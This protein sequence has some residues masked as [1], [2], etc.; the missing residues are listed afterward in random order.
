VVRLALRLPGEIE[1]SFKRLRRTYP[2]LSRAAWDISTQDEFEFARQFDC[3]RFQGGFVTRRNDWHGRVLAPQVLAVAT[4]INE[5]RQGADMRELAKVL[6]QDIAM[7]YRLLRYVNT[8]ARGLNHQLS[9][10]E[11]ALLVLGQEQLDRWL[12]LLMLGGS[13]G[14]NT[15][16][17]ETALVRARFLEL[18]GEGRF[19]PGQC[20]RLFV[21]GLFSM[22]DIALRVPM[23]EALKPLHLPEA[24]TQALLKREGPFGPYLSLVEA[25]ERCDAERMLKHAVAIGLTTRK[26]WLG[27]AH[28]KPRPSPSR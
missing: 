24:A 21:L 7:S 27:S 13:L 14:G 26:P 11:Q 18:L 6:K 19:A 16:L 12:T 25:V 3:I 22:L 9:S 8:A 17:M 10:I 20:E 23:E 5:L 1:E 4:L 15:A 28:P 2:Q